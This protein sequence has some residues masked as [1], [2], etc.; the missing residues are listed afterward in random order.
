ML[1][2]KPFIQSFIAKPP[3]QPAHSGAVAPLTFPNVVSAVLWR[4]GL[5]LVPPVWTN[6][7]VHRHYDAPR[8][9]VNSQ[10]VEKT[11]QMTM[12]FPGPVRSKVEGVDLGELRLRFQDVWRVDLYG[13]SVGVRH[14]G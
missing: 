1:V 13:L 5:N 8:P 12:S 2:N 3:E 10:P 4:P 14:P 11:C 9:M 6:E 7:S